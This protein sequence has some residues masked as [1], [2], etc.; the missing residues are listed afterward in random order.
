MRL[1]TI[2]C[3]FGLFVALVT[4]KSPICFIVCKYFN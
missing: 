4:E 1:E 3:T 2:N